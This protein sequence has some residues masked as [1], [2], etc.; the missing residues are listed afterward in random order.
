LAVVHRKPLLAGVVR[1]KC[2]CTVIKS[3][4]SKVYTSIFIK[5][6]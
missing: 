4:I 3:E 5:Y 1:H 2:Y 6:H